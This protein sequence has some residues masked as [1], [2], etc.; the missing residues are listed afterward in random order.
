[1]N[2]YLILV[3]IGGTFLKIS[4]VSFETDKISIFKKY[5]MPG[6]LQKGEYIKE[7]DPMKLL[8]MCLSGIHEIIENDKNIVGIYIAGQMGGWVATDNQN[9]PITNLIT[10]QD[11]RVMQIKNMYEETLD[12]LEHNLGSSWKLDSGNEIR[13]GLPLIS[14]FYSLQNKTLPTGFRF[15]T[16]ISWVAANLCNKPYYVL[17]ITDFASTGMYNLK[18]KNLNF[19]EIFQDTIE[20]PKVDNNIIEIGFF[21]QTRIPVY[22]AVGDQQASLLGSGIK[23]N[24]I[25]VNIG[26]GGQVAKLGRLQEVGQ[27]QVRPFFDNAYLITKTHLPSGRNISLFLEKILKRFP[28]DHDFKCLSRIKFDNDSPAPQNE[29]INNLNSKSISDFDKEV[30]HEIKT[31][32]YSLSQVYVNSIIDLGIKDNSEILLAGGIGQKIIYIGQHIANH[33]DK[34]I[35]IS[36]A[37]ETTLQGLFEIGKQQNGK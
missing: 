16:L 33:T 17:N 18:I 35:F 19:P 28:T 12:N 30:L 10:W 5:P 29:N 6:F 15:H 34:K 14:L 11:Q 27:N 1:M 7:L 32:L 37:A 4:K 26:T 36:E 22:S 20:F 8:S 31:Y 24:S 21:Q 25:I 2:Q 3:D 13:P 23:S 9:N